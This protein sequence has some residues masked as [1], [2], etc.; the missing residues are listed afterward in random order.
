M[1]QKESLSSLD[2]A[3]SL[4]VSDVILYERIPSRLQCPVLPLPAICQH[5]PGSGS[6][7]SPLFL[8]TCK[9][10]TVFY[11]EVYAPAL[12]R[13]TSKMMLGAKQVA[14]RRHDLGQ[15]GDIFDGT[16]EGV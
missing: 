10:V 13:T 8:H 11:Q 15:Q 9:Y 16:F 4:C 14:G 3:P 5:L 1:E 7:Y 12:D 6:F 2:I